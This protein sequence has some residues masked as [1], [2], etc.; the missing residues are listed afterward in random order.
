MDDMRYIDAIQHQILLAKKN[1][2]DAYISL[3]TIGQL[4]KRWIVDENE[5]EL[6]DY[7]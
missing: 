2:D 6:E 1:P 5:E 3:E 7:N 4:I